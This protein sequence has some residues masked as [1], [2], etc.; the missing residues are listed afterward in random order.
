MWIFAKHGFLSIVQHQH[1]PQ[2]LLVRGRVRGD[3]QRYF[4]AAKVART[5][6]RDYLYRTV[7]G[8]EEVA[9]RIAAA[10]QAIDYCGA[11]GTSF[12]SVVGK[13]REPYYFAVWDTMWEMQEQLRT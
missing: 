7:L 3:I 5:E 13:N 2:Q 4:P 6:N 11:K 9:D 10:V 12:K 8:K 1:H